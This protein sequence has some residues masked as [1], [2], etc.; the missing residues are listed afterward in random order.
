MF[1]AASML[2]GALKGFTAEQLLGALRFVKTTS[3]NHSHVGGFVMLG[4]ALIGGALLS[5]AAALIRRSS[6]A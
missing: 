2:I 3:D 4:Y 6:S 5:A 1:L